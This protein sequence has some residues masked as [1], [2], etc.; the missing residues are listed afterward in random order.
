ML[1]RRAMI[2]A[3][4]RVPQPWG[5]E[6]EVLSSPSSQ[7]ALNYFNVTFPLKGKACDDPPTMNE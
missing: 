4:L 7:M 1:P 2:L 3:H 5:S 6:V